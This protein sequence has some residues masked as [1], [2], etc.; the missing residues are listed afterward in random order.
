MSLYVCED[1]NINVNVVFVE[2]C[3]RADYRNENGM[4]RSSI[5]ILHPLELRTFGCQNIQS[6][7]T[8][9]LLAIDRQ[10]KFNSEKQMSCCVVLR[11]LTLRYGGCPLTYGVRIGRLL[12]L[13]RS[14][15]APIWAVTCR[16]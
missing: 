10:V 8:M 2:L 5:V 15:A 14:P 11:C 16:A 12:C 6:S 4:N 9:E 13:I 3:R 7:H 1:V